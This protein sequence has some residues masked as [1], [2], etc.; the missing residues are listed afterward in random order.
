MYLFNFN[1]ILLAI[2][3]DKKQTNKKNGKQGII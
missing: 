3:F 2:N 1:K